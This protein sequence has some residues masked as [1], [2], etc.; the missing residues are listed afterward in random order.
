[1]TNR[2]LWRDGNAML[3]EKEI[4]LYYQLETILRNRILSGEFSSEAPIPSEEA[5]SH[6][7]EVSRITVRRALASLE[8]DNLIVRKRG[9][10]TFVSEDGQSVSSPKL[11][12]SIE[13]IISMGVK[14]TVEVVDTSWVTPPENIRESLKLM[15]NQKALKVEKVR[16]IHD[17]SFS[18]VLNFI[19]SNIGEKVPR[20]LLSEKPML[21]I[22]EEDLGVNVKRAVQTIG[23]AIAD[24]DIAGKLRIRVGEPLLKVQRTVYDV[25]EIPVEHVLAYYRSD[26]YYYT[27]NQIRMRAGENGKWDD[28]SI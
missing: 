9:K 15:K 2:S 17:D 8:K 24:A 19:P 20:D 23:A 12:G 5:L 1:M 6:E 28:N 26:K 11:S 22:L 13:D 10:G 14:T 7:Y 16:Y 18:H 21:M 3:I 27:V 4:P 25:D